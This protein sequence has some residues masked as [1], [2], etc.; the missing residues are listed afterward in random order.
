MRHTMTIA[1]AMLLAACG[2]ENTRPT[3]PAPPAVI[4]IPE[5][6]YVPIEAEYT[7]RCAWVRDGKLEEMPTV[8]RGRKTCLEKYESQFDA[9]ERKQGSLVG[10]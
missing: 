8:S 3:P 4:S 2:K 6:H 1:A 9:I 5:K 7:K 10:D